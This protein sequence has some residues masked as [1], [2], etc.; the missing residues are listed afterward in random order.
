MLSISYHHGDKRR[1]QIKI[2]HEGGPFWRRLRRSLKARYPLTEL[3]DEKAIV[4][5]RHTFYSMFEEIREEIDSMDMDDISIDPDVIDDIQ[6]FFAIDTKI[7]NLDQNVEDVPADKI[8]ERLE[9]EGWDMESIMPTEFQLKNLSRMC[10]YP[11]G[12]ASFSVPGAGKTVEACAFF[13]YHKKPESSMIVVLPRVGYIAWE[14]ELEKCLGLVP[15]TDVIRI[16]RGVEDNE[17]IIEENPNASVFLITYTRFTN[18]TQLMFEILDRGN[19]FLVLDESHRIKNDSARSSATRDLSMYAKHR[20][21]LTGT[22][23]PNRTEDI[24]R[25]FDFLYPAR[26]W[27]HNKVV[28]TMKNIQVRTKKSDLGLLEP[29]E[30][31][32]DV[33]MDPLQEEIYNLI[34]KHQARKLQTVDLSDRNGLEELGRAVLTVIQA[35]S[36]PMLLLKNPR[37]PLEIKERILDLVDEEGSEAFPKIDWVCKK[38]RELAKSGEKVIIW[39]SFVENVKLIDSKLKDLGS[40][41]IVGSTPSLSGSNTDTD[42]EGDHREGII[43]AFKDDPSRMVLVANPAAAGESISLHH[44]C[45][46]AIYVDRTY[47]AGNFVQSRDRIHRYG[48]KDGIVT[49]REKDTYYY[50]LTTEGTIDTQVN[51]SL[52]RKIKNMARLLNDDSLTFEPIGIPSSDGPTGHG[53]DDDDCSSIIEGFLGDNIGL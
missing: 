43:K 2:K 9:V 50:Y 4:T 24:E 31:R 22:P 7:D 30:L 23:T 35:A 33:G 20:L 13:A 46:H 49:C 38:T 12:A 8:L 32:P 17:R 5:P 34:R 19:C 21:I 45:R 1:V 16:D 18:N 39:S 44:V 40:R 37:V 36:N 29:K 6:R 47:N 41:Y 28:E 15:G 53:L 42:A 14:E 27:P 51:S 10:A 3:S 11:D 48:M 26:H 25:Q 52:S